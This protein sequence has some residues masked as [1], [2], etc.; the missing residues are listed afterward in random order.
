MAGADLAKKLIK[1]NR[2]EGKVIALGS[3][4]ENQKYMLVKLNNN[5]GIIYQ[6]DYGS[7]IRFSNNINLEDEVKLKLLD[8]YTAEWQVNKHGP[9]QVI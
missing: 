2:N 8:E 5:K 6:I 1:E 4:V 3:T 7:D 9:E